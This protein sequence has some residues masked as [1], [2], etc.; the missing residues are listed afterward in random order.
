GTIHSFCADLLRERPVEAGID[1][2]FEVGAEDV[3]RPLFDL[4]FDR[5]FEQQLAQ[6][7]EG[8]RRILRRRTREEGPRESL[9]AAARALSERRDFP[10]P[11]KRV[12][13]FDRERFIDELIEEMRDLS[14]WAGKGDPQDYFN[15]SLAQIDNLF[16][17]DV[18]RVEQISG[19][20]YDAIEARIPQFLRKWKSEWK[21]FTTYPRDFPK[22]DLMNRRDNLKA[23]LDEFV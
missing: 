15:R 14:S 7:G 17:S 2:M 3:V 12:A 13:T 9:R 21:G 8:V 11:W 1:P 5:W 16:L 10:T 19:R 4:A 22:P 6:P 18:T 20:D 23:R